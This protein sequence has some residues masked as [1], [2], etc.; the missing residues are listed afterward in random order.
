[1][2]LLRKSATLPILLSTFA[3]VTP[4]VCSQE[5]QQQQQTPPKVEFGL[6]PKM[7]VPAADTSP[8]P[9][10]T[11]KN[12]KRK[13]SEDVEVSGGQQWVDTKLDLL[14]GDRVA[15][16]ATGSVQFQMQDP[17]GP[18]GLSRGW[19]DLLRKLPV[20]SAGRGALV[21]RIGTGDIAEPFLVGASRDFQVRQAGR[22]YLAI[23]Q[24]Q[25][26][27]PSGSFKAKI[28]I[29]PVEGTTAQTPA[30]ANFTPNEL[31]DLFTPDFFKKLPRR[32]ADAEGNQG[33]MVNFLILGSEDQVRLAFQNAGW[34]KVD[35]TPKDAIL[36]GLISSISKQAYVEMPMSS[37]NLFGRPQDYGFAHAEP[38]SVIAT[39]HHLRIWRAPFELGGQTLWVGAGTHDIGFERDQR[40]NG[41]T[42]KIDPAVD[43]ERDFIGQSLSSTGMVAKLGYVTPPDPLTEAR[44]ATGGSF[45][46]DGRIL[47]MQ[48][49]SSGKDRR[50]AFADMFCSVL[51]DENP[52]GGEWGDCSQ[53]IETKPDTAKITLGPISKKYRILVLP[54]FM[55]SCV[56]SVQALGKGQERLRKDFGLDV[57]YLALPN[58]SSENNGKLIADY[59]RKHAN[60]SRKY[61]VIGY[62]K[63]APDLQVGLAHD[64]DAAKNVAAFVSLAGAVGGSPVANTIPAMIDRYAKSLNLGTCQG[65][66]AAAARSLRNDVRHTFL[67]EHPDPIVPTYSISAMSDK[68]NTSKMLLQAWQILFAYDAQ[69]DSQLTRQD[70]IVPG[71]TLLGALKADHLAVALAFEDSADAQVKSMMDHNHY[72]RTALTEAIVRFVINDLESAPVK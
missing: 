58:D 22:L 59:L 55:S 48:L 18:D 40:N 62:S 45:H 8:S 10:E 36:H 46:S 56:S 47:V 52:D 13:T 43:G 9:S 34:V 30:Q 26:D 64:P 29:T 16:T 5:S 61:I 14:P 21:A 17:N 23:N 35:A 38:L 24:S 60:D 11:P 57:E 71:S 1:M 66:I 15:I 3:L 54:G 27:S 42:H 51:R 53:Y 72:P 6:R 33:D 65:D 31:S 63:G 20:N 32:V 4:Y 70:A 28:K 49:A 50:A 12:S 7:A 69:E 41:I 25:D 39:R 68:T 67:A 19:F 37:L 2:Y 44:T